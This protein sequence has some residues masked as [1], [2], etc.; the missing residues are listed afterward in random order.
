MKSGIII[1]L[2]FF[3]NFIFA[4]DYQLDKNFGDHG[5]SLYHF[6][7]EDIIAIAYDGIIWDDSYLVECFVDDDNGENTI[8][9]KYDK[10]GKI[11]ESFADNGKLLTDV[12]DYDGPLHFTILPNGNIAIAGVDDSD[13]LVIY[14]YDKNGKR[15]KILAIDTTYDSLYPANIISDNKNIYIGGVYGSDWF[16]GSEDLFIMKTDLEGNIDSTFGENGLFIYKND[17]L[18]VILNALTF[19]DGGLLFS[20]AETGSSY[21]DVTY[22]LSE[23]DFSGKLNQ[24]FGNGGIAKMENVE[25]L[26]GDYGELHLDKNSN[27]YFRIAGSPFVFKFD[28]NGNPVL[29]YGNNGMSII[30]FDA[31]G[32]MLM[33]FSRILDD[34]GIFQFGGT[35]EYFDKTQPLIMKLMPDGYPDTTFGYKGFLQGY[36]GGNSIFYNGIMNDDG[37]FI[38]IGGQGIDGSAQNVLLA[39]YKPVISAVKEISGE[40]SNIIVYPNPVIGNKFHVVLDLKENSEIEVSLF[41]ITGKK[42][43]T[44]YKDRANEG[45]NDFEF[46]VRSGIMPGTYLLKIMSKKGVSYKKISVLN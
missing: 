40:I 28:K 16:S 36:F 42:I 17:S 33:G 15:D 22:S 7:G 10:N 39:K 4:Q 21:E 46:V 1:A 41:S 27:I 11:D 30:D 12:L 8:F 24:S 44:F 32:D 5:V 6:Q 19:F 20:F 34:G 26:D 13:F 45:E 18:N 31:Q 29:S 23:L 2:M 38:A 14:E 43:D 3:T 25:F 35:D 37:S 9:I